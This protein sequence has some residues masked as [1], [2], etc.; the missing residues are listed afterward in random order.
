MTRNTR[1]RVVCARILLAY[2]LVAYPLPLFS[3]RRKESPSP[4]TEAP[5]VF[6]FRGG[7]YSSLPGK[8][9]R[10]QLPGRPIVKA[11]VRLLADRDQIPLGPLQLRVILDR[12]D[13]VHRRCLDAPAVPQRLTAQAFVPVKDARPKRQPSLALVIHRQKRKAP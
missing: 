5:S 4:V 8:P 2:F 7:G 13:M 11:V 3:V 12:V 10:R 6:V 1:A 9:G